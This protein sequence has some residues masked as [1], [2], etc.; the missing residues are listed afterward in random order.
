VTRA[1][2]ES[3]A[4]TEARDV[5]W[6]E[7]AIPGARVAF[8]TRLGGSSAAPYDSLNLGILTDDD[9]ARVAAN[10]RALADA[11]GRTH[12][13]IVYGLQVHGTDVQVHQAPRDGAEPVRSDAQATA[14]TELTPLVLVADCLPLALSAPG[15]VAMA[16]CGWRGIAS[17]VIAN[18][19]AALEELS[20]CG[21]GEIHA[22]LGPGIRGCCYEVGPAVR[23]EFER[24]G[25]VDALLPARRLDL[26]TAAQT[27]LARSGVG[28]E[29]FTDCAICTSCDPERFFSH[30][31]DGGVTGRQAGLIWRSS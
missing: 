5:P 2:L 31:R 18:A 25:H 12:D 26:A 27:A 16:H 9:P 20:G 11:L 23:A 14:S 1:G 15:A 28:G 10:R 21:R 29:R 17:G 7:I 3:F 19:V 6:L 24:A 30:R 22:A 8:S 4:W 13:G